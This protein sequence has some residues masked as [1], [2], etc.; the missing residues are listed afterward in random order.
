MKKTKKDLFL[1]IFFSLYI[2]L[3]D[4]FA[5][6]LS[7]SFPLL[8]ISRL[9]LVFAFFVYVIG[10]NGIISKKI[11]KKKN[12][13]ILFW[14]Y[15]IL[16]I[17]SNLY[18]INVTNEA[19]QRI[20]T[21]IFEELMLLYIIVNYVDSMDKFNKAIN[22]IAISSGIVALIAIIGGMK[23]KYKVLLRK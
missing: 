10:K 16:M 15:I 13:Q 20:F 4:Y 23:T 5:I 12:T 6:E 1:I 17:V 7:E 3:P 9:L 11:F 19:A 21:L 18:Y 8:T 14:I 2:V 22:T